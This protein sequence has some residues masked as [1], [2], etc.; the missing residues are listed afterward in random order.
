M[1][2]HTHPVKARSEWIQACHFHDL[3]EPEVLKEVSRRVQEAAQTPLVLLDLDSTLYEVGPRTFQILQE[4]I[5]TDA[6]KEFQTVA[7]RIQTLEPLHVGYSIKDTFHALGLDL[8]APEVQAAVDAAKSFWSARFFTSDYLRYDR[9]YPGAAQFARELHDLGAHLIYLTGRD[10]PN[11][12]RGTRTNLMRDGFPWEEPRTHL[13]TKRAPEVP[14]LDHKKDAASYIRSHGEL[15]ASFENEP[16]NLV[17]LA[18]LFPQSMH[19]FVE[20]IYSDRAAPVRKGLY[21]IKHF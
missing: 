1:E 7:E 8:T 21:R 6:G 2:I 18:D 12:G 4:W 16:L 5:G 11:M 17:A 20:T 10:E 14:D 9:V 15:V 3:S 19:V 13:L